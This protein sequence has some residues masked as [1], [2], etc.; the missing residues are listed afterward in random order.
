MERHRL[1]FLCIQEHRLKGAGKIFDAQSWAQ[2]AG[3]QL[4]TGEAIATEATGPS[5]TSAGTGVLA[6]AYIGAKAFDLKEMAQEVVDGFG[7]SLTG[8]SVEW[9]LARLQ[10]VKLEAGFKH[11]FALV[12]I[13]GLHGIGVSGPNVILFEVLA[14][15]L[16]QIGLPWA[17]G[18][19]WNFKLSELAG[20]GWLNVVDGAEVLQV[21][22]LGD[23]ASECRADDQFAFLVQSA[24]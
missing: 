17:V 4:F 12:S 15:A 23:V 8:V 2:K 16:Q 19:D 5:A 3:L 1:H 14:P 20:S 13:Y 22:K 10:T 21:A 18:G 24:V 7:G 9:I 11:I 6:A